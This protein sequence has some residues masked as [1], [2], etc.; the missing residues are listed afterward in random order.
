MGLTSGSARWLMSR[1]TSHAAAAGL[2]LSGE[3]RARPAHVLA[4]DPYSCQGPPRPGTLPRPGPYLEGPG[5][6]PRDPTCLLWDIQTCTYRGP[7]SLCG[8]SEPTMHPR[9]YYL[10]LPRGAFKPAHVVKSGVILCV[11]WR[12]RTG[13]ASSYCRRGYP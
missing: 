2:R 11:A 7:V 4:P 8:G 3:R 5:A 13:A 1:A 12:C 9:M 10:S 6:H